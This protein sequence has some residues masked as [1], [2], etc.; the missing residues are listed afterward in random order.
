MAS[1]DEHMSG[2]AVAAEP[3]MPADALVPPADASRALGCASLEASAALLS[4]PALPTPLSTSVLLGPALPG[5]VSASSAGASSVSH[6]L[7]N[8]SRHVP[9]SRTARLFDTLSR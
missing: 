2:T 3:A 6:P 8:S 4:W 7:A 1:L 5:S 9:Q